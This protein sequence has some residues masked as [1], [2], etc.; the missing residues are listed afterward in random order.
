[1][2]QG[3]L[4]AQEL[5]RRTLVLAALQGATP[6]AGKR[7]PPGATVSVGS[8]SGNGLVIPEK[9]EL[10]AYTLVS[11]G[12]VLHLALPLH[13]QTTVWLGGEPLEIKGFIRDLKRAR[14]ELPDA[15]PLASDR[16]IIRYASGISFIGRFA[17]P[18]E[19][20]VSSSGPV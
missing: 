8:N 3:P 12:S 5:S 7:F 16:F 4:S 1:M 14:P 17:D 2:T 13:V 15:L 20:A 10:T 18:A 11:H 9:F 6:I 19:E